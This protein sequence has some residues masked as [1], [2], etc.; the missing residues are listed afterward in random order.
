GTVEAPSDI[1]AREELNNLGFSILT[2][3]QS[4]EVV[5]QL[6][7]LQKFIFEAV[8]RNSKIVN[9][10]IPA[11]SRTEAYQ[12]LGN[13]YG[14][15]VTAI[16]KEGSTTEEI[17]NAKEEGKKLMGSELK[18]PQNTGEVLLKQ[19]E[20]EKKREQM[21]REKIEFVLGKIRELL[22]SFEHDIDLDQK[23]EIN[24]KIDKLLRIK[25]STNLDYILS[26]AKEVLNTIQAQEK[27]LASKGLRDKELAL[28]LRTK[29]LLDQLNISTKPKTLSADIIQKIGLWESSHL[30]DQNP[31]TKF[32][33]NILIK[34]KGFFETPEEILILKNQISVY[35]KQLWEFLKLYFKEKSPEYRQKVKNG[36]GAVWRARKIAKE[37]LLIAKKAIK[38]RKNTQNI[39]QL[40]T[41]TLTD[42]LNAFSGWLLAF[43]IIYYFLGLYLNS[44]SFG[45]A[46]IPSQFSIY[47][48]HFFKYIL[49]IV[50][51][52]H[53]CT[54]LK[55]NFFRKSIFANFLLV[56]LFIFGSLFAILN[57]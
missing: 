28:Q 27:S 14:L 31:F 44:K 47:E 54:A 34:I 17:N 16:W 22:S 50:F 15:T 12:K 39:E 26:T 53:T 25:N 23:A 43:Y 10:T 42:E 30:N 1:V 3:E 7:G 41:S 21:V 56:P 20:D 8:D 37:N 29:S 45:L 9:G 35:N 48:S 5:K 49:L 52:L 46:S 18:L 24:K 55:V 40:K 2:L 51:L 38:E 57:F 32:L 33:H 36:I 6:S 19:S 11:S 13:E 4:N